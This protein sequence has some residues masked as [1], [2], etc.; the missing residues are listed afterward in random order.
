M[1]VD[2]RIGDSAS[3]I[4][5][6][7]KPNNPVISLGA[8]TATQ[9]IEGGGVMVGASSIMGV[10]GGVGDN[11]ADVTYSTK[12]NNRVVSLGTTEYGTTS[13]TNNGCWRG[14]RR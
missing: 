5:Y 8:T 9:R 6:S 3:D 1:G 4:T 13:V 7:T 11:A 2:P 12:P 10:D 14:R